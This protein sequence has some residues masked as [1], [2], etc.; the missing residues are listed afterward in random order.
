VLL[1]QINEAAAEGLHG[2]AIFSALRKKFGVRVGAS[3]LYSELKF[4][5]KTRFIESNWDVTSGKA[6]RKYKI[7]AKAKRCLKSMFRA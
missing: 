2:Y 7:T 3:T 5:K 4:F 6:R 1:S